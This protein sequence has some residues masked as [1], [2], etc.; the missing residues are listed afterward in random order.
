MGEKN[1]ETRHLFMAIG[2]CILIF[3]PI[4]LVFVPQS[5][6]NTV[7]FTKNLWYVFTPRMN[8]VVYAVEFLLLFVSTMLLFLLD[9]KKISIILSLI[10]ASLAV[11]CF[12][13]DSQSHESLTEDFISYSP[14]FSLK[15]YT[16]P[17]NK[18]KSI[19]LNG[20]KREGFSEYKFVF[21]DGN[22]MNLR[23]DNYF[24]VIE[25]QLDNKLQEMKL[26]IKVA[27]KT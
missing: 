21:T 27:H 11:G 19:M 8:F 10:S 4:L 14:L 6:S 20:Y 22:S 26:G 15:D 25:P 13:V 9:I 5:V 17:W 18:V 2:I 3:S 12:F 7:H 16:Y 24:K 1:Y 23:Y